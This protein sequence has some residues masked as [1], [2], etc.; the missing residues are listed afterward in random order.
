MNALVAHDEAFGAIEAV[1]ME[2]DLSRL[3]SEQRVT[4]YNRV[5]SSVGLNPLTRPF[6]YIK[7]NGKLVLYAK[8]DC[9]DQL[10]T[11]RGVSV[12]VVGRERIDDLYVVTA[13]ATDKAGRV[14]ESTGA[15]SISGLRGENLANAFMKAE[16]KAK[17]RVTLSLCGLGIIDESEI[18]S[19]AGAERVNPEAP[20][21]RIPSAAP[22]TAGAGSGT[23]PQRPPAPANPP[24][25]AAKAAAWLR[26]EFKTALETCRD[27]ADISALTAADADRM[28]RIN[29]NYPDLA[30]EMA[31]MVAERMGAVS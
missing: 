11:I 29:A 15:V 8:R 3:N 18:D 1:L 6:D 21:A 16:T 17:R 24:N 2:G 7:L 28:E 30:E 12:S 26:G 22:K 20:V 10:R 19:V 25:G 13:R 27:A 9:T 31:Q 23:P 14:D 4:Y 5:C